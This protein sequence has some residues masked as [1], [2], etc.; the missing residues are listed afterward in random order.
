[1][2]FK[3]IILSVV[4]LLI[5]SLLIVLL[6]VASRGTWT[7]LAPEHY[8]LI[9]MAE[10]TPVVYNALQ[11]KDKKKIS[12]AVS[13]AF[14]ENRVEVF[15]KDKTP[16][17]I[18]Y[19]E[20]G[21]PDIVPPLVF[22]KITPENTLVEIQK[23]VFEISYE[24]LEGNKKAKIANL[25]IDGKT[26]LVPA[27]PEYS[28][29]GLIPSPDCT[30]YI[31]TTEKGLWLLEAGKQVP[32]KISKDK[33]N[34]KTYNDL[35]NEL[36]KKLAGIEGP[37]IV[38]WNDNPI[39]SP[40]G[41]KIVYMT[42]RDCVASGGSSLW[43]YDLATGEERPLIT[44]AGGE[45]H[46]CQGWMDNN[47]IVYVKSAQGIDQYFI[48]DVEGNPKELRLDGKESR[49]LSIYNDMIAYYY[50]QGSQR[51]FF[52]MVKIDPE[53]SLDDVSVIYEKSIEGAL[54]QTMPPAFS[55]TRRNFSPDGSK[56]AYLYAPDSDETVP[57]IAIV[58]LD[59]RE[60]TI[61]KEALSKDKERT[62][63]YDFDWLD[64]QRL[65]VRISRVIDGM[66]E[67]SSW[68]YKIGKV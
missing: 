20:L 38:W 58:S 3:L 37:A 42:N 41:S 64:N 25:S 54:R 47:H 22:K 17:D 2:K 36:R 27:D 49:I 30:K 67:I 23:A 43:L 50:S 1:M 39:F 11:D 31:L 66:N 14:M 68:I 40:D 16:M 46:R 48:T 57:Y 19:T 10:N 18:N 13:G 51:D 44:N 60:E 63:F 5:I 29:Y 8:H 65:L 34:G 33:F 28:S 32:S 21:R 35:R 62:V 55:A 4:G 24:D 15:D 6:L 12:E 45:H 59:T 56:L 61:L 9:A 52:R 26:I 7:Y 53:N